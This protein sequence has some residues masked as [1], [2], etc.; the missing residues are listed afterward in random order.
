MYEITI[1]PSA[2]RCNKRSRTAVAAPEVLGCRNGDGAAFAQL[3]ERMVVIY[4]DGQMPN[5]L[6][7]T[8]L[9]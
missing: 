3:P 5:F 2:E 9:K 4:S 6:V 8:L 1:L 7:K